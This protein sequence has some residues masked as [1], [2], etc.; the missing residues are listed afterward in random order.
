MRT[1]FFILI[2]LFK[3][4]LLIGQNVLKYEP[5]NVY[6]AVPD[7]ITGLAEDSGNHIFECNFYQYDYQGMFPKEGKRWII[8]LDYCKSAPNAN[9][10]F[11]M[12]CNL[13]DVYKS[14]K[15]KKL[16]EIYASDSRTV[17]EEILENPTVRER[18]FQIMGQID[19]F[20]IMCIIDAELGLCLYV[21]AGDNPE[22]LPY[23]MGKENGEYK[24]LSLEDTLASSLNVLYGLYYSD[25]P[26]DLLTPI[27]RDGDKTINRK[28]NCP[29]TENRLQRN[30]DNDKYGDACD[31]CPNVTNPLQSD[32]DFDRAGD[33]CDNC[34]DLYNPDQYDPDN[35]KLG[36]KCDNC[37]E[38]AN[39]D[40]IDTDN[41]KVGDACDNCPKLPNTEQLDSDN[42]GV[43]DGCDSCPSI[44]N[45]DQS[46]N[47]EQLKKQRKKN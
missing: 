45:K 19:K 15:E 11:Y 35:D 36:A 1:T 39:K 26:S 32:T 18:F 25:I 6:L 20:E 14:Q 2:L 8:D 46:L 22:I 27:D 44:P 29:C 23:Y 34:P 38:V 40:Q 21:K 30:S 17:L 16:L 13:L 3:V 24:F 28:D 42:D 10:P 4:Y 41:D 9:D 31:N 47:C 5:Y 33:A 43:G 37:P 12:F 7:S